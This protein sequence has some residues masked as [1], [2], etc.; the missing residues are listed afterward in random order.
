MLYSEEFSKRKDDEAKFGWKGLDPV[1]AQLT[2][3]Q[4]S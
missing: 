1:V 2:R 3:D 4:A